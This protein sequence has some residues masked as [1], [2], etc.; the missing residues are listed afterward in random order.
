[1]LLN[2][3]SAALLATAAYARSS[4][5]VHGVYIDAGSGGSRVHLYE[6][7]MP[8]SGAKHHS[9]AASRRPNLPRELPQVLRITP[10]LETLAGQR[11]DELRR[12]VAEYMSKLV[13]FAAKHLGAVDGAALART[14]IFLGA[15]AGVRELQQRHRDALLV[16]VREY[17]SGGDAK[18][19]VPF[20]F[21]PHWARVLAGE[22][23]AAFG[24]LA[25]N[26]LEGK[27]DADHVSIST[28]RG[29]MTSTVGAL[30]M[31]GEST[32]IT[33]LPQHDILENLYT[34][35]L[36][37]QP[38]QL[39]LYSHSYLFY[40]RAA[41]AARIDAS[42]LAAAPD[43]SRVSQPCLARGAEWRSPHAALSRAGTGTG[44][45]GR[46]GHLSHS[47][48]KKKQNR[49]GNDVTFLGIGD[50]NACADLMRRALRKVPC[51]DSAAGCGALNGAYQPRLTDRT[52]TAFGDFSRVFRSIGLPSSKHELFSVNEVEHAARKA[53]AP[54]LRKGAKR[55]EH[56]E[57]K[58]IVG[59]RTQSVCERAIYYWVLLRDGY[60]FEPD[61]KRLSFWSGKTSLTWTLGAMIEKVEEI[62]MLRSA[63]ASALVAATGWA[64]VA[65]TVWWDQAEDGFCPESCIWKEVLSS[66]ILP[67]AVFVVFIIAFGLAILSVQCVR[68]SGCSASKAKPSLNSR[69]RL[70]RER[71]EEQ[72]QQQQQQQQQKGG[73]YCCGLC[74]AK[75]NAGERMPL[76]KA[77]GAARGGASEVRGAASVAAAPSAAAL[78]TSPP[79]KTTAF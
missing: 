19:R 72:Q 50:F 8:P 67:G 22:E 29:E 52:F 35:R 1:M 25:L 63:S 20:A 28:P 55:E 47:A 36:A 39:R 46:G 6:W 43:V 11:D 49:H 57:L 45:N 70:A 34:V 18:H 64:A 44:L 17:L 30:D 71:Q 10:G 23:E 69:A 37:W 60:G 33:F 5:L 26:A 68:R 62:E 3:V 40:G 38:R 12:G 48:A 24:W 7:S 59:A 79:P 15:T 61:A 16:A 2:L 65:D 41:I 78:E 54:S 21:K 31:G 14:P 76:T 13:D 58:R 74:P 42:V 51:A 32:Q 53:C 4:D 77:R 73:S 27:L 9:H 56:A 75:S 66:P